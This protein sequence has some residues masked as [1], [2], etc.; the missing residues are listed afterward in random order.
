MIRKNN[1]IPTRAIDDLSTQGVV[2]NFFS[3]DDILTIRASI[4]VASF[5]V[6][7]FLC[8]YDHIDEEVALSVDYAAVLNNPD[9]EKTCQMISQEQ[10]Y[11]QRDLFY[12]AIWC[13][14]FFSWDLDIQSIANRHA[15]VQ[16]MDRYK[17]Y[18]YHFAGEK[19]NSG[20]EFKCPY[21]LREARSVL[22][23][24]V[25]KDIDCEKIKKTEVVMVRTHD[26]QAKCRELKGTHFICIDFGLYFFLHQWARIILGCYRLA[27]ATFTD[28]EDRKI[29]IQPPINS[30]AQYVRKMCG[31]L[32]RQ[33]E[34][35]PFR[36]GTILS[37]D[38][39]PCFSMVDG[40]TA[41]ELIG[42]QIDFILAHEYS[43][44]GMG[45]ESTVDGELKADEY[46]LNWLSKNKSSFSILNKRM[47][48]K[49]T[50]EEFKE[51]DPLFKKKTDRIV[52][53]VELLFLLYDVYYYIRDK[54]MFYKHNNEYPAVY[55]RALQCQQ[56]YSNQIDEDSLI[57]FARTLV[58]E[59]K[60]CYPTL[61]K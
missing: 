59:I 1:P 51:S 9:L 58:D 24:C 22:S 29:K 3:K 7:R 17:A 53:S 50:K 35:G 49:E 42:W 10:S 5:P 37:L 46:A 47:M 60:K 6:L 19:V 14:V 15:I 34:E 16:A 43:H 54:V 2:S 40:S 27:N 45:Y 38:M 48:N 25:P 13:L 56:H 30:A 26:I 8:P 52:E 61:E 12:M 41:K 44:I 33:Q 36:D 39:F 28:D 11:R 23:Y 21:W 57:A 20:Y 32:I 31:F 55:E 4:K 18:V